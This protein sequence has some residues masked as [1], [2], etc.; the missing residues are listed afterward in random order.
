MVDYNDDINTN[1]L[2]GIFYTRL[3]NKGSKFLLYAEIFSQG[4]K[5]FL[6][7]LNHGWIMIIH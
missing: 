3:Q 5:E 1:D 6:K 4:G 2:V 7:T